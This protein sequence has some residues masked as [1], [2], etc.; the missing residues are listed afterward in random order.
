MREWSLGRALVLGVVLVALAGGG[1]LWLFVRRAQAQID[2]SGLRA[3]DL[4]A[5]RVEQQVEAELGRA[6]AA[7]EQIRGA[8]E[9]GA[10]SHDDAAGVEALLYGVLAADAHLEEATFTR[11]ESTGFDAAGDALVEER[12]RW[13]LSIVREPSGAL[14]TSLVGRGA[15][16]FER[17]TR[18]RGPG[19]RFDAAPFGPPTAAADPTEHA[20]FSVLASRGGRG[21]PIWS[22]L[23][24]AEIDAALPE[25]A[26]RVVVSVQRSVTGPGGRLLGVVRVAIVS[27]ELDAIATRG[28]RECEGRVVLLAASRPDGAPRTRLDLVA[29]VDPSDRFLV[30]GADDLRLESARPPPEVAA[31]LG[32]DVAAGLDPARPVADGALDV[33]AEPWAATLRPI[34]GDD[35]RSEAAAAG[36]G[37][38]GTRGWLVAVLAPRSLYTRE[39]DAF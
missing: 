11:A 10:V 27:A 18:A 37:G 6:S 22:D 36:L 2:A 35:A 38:G 1:G 3:R 23:H 12:P 14:P 19:D 17:T 5:A 39:L 28:S 7:L 16:G 32:S 31:L 20:T 34:G 21:R 4:A 29:R 30:V 8:V 9:S 33:G 24:L 15:A 26:R 13:Q 25:A